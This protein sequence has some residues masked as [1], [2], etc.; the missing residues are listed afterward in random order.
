MNFGKLMMESGLECSYQ[1]SH[2]EF[3]LKIVPVHHYISSANL[4]RIKN[5]LDVRLIIPER[6]Y[7]VREQTFGVRTKAT[8][9]P[10]TLWTPP[11][12]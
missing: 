10:V 12:T 4:A 1:V 11:R 7:F 2:P 8:Q 6:Y 3:A 5:P 9:S